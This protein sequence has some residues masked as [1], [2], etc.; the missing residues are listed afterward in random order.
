[1]Q[2]E[3]PP[4]LEKLHS[5]STTTP[6]RPYT[7]TGYRRKIK[8]LPHGPGERKQHPQ[9]TDFLTALLLLWNEKELL[10]TLKIFIAVLNSSKQ[11]PYQD[12]LFSTNVMFDFLGK[13]LTFGKLLEAHLS[14]RNDPEKT[15]T[16][17]R[18][19]TLR[20]LAVMGIA[21]DSRLL[22]LTMTDNYVLSDCMN[23]VNPCKIDA[24]N[25][26]PECLNLARQC[27]KGYFDFREL[28]LRCLRF[29][30]MM[31]TNVQTQL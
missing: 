6:R 2:T 26:F 20:G 12:T 25:F 29:W 3:N 8:F 5:P 14:Q 11:W 4:E 1:M 17:N 24:G 18:L 23:V 31:I 15:E 7:N 19:F 16:I 13:K 9:G 22:A 28:G 10:A 21:F 27:I 30:M